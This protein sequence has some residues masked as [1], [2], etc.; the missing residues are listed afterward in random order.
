[1]AIISCAVQYIPVAS[2]NRFGIV[3][4]RSGKG[5]HSLPV[6]L[7]DILGVIQMTIWLEELHRALRW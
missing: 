3:W 1:M 6:S 2:E 7:R 5:V 4:G